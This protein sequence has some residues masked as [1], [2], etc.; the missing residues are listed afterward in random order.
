[1]HLA[2]AAATR[3]AALRKQAKPS[4]AVKPPKPRPAWPAGHTVPK[5]PNF[6]TVGK[7]LSELAARRKAQLLADSI[8]QKEELERR[9]QAV[10]QRRKNFAKSRTVPKSPALKGKRKII[11]AEPA[12]KRRFVPNKMPDFGRAP[13]VRATTKSKAH[14][15][16]NREGGSDAARRESYMMKKG[17]DAGRGGRRDSVRMER[18]VSKPFGLQG[19]DR[20]NAVAELRMMQMEREAEEQNRRRTFRPVAMRE[21]ILDGPTFVPRPKATAVTEAR[22]L[23][24]DASERRARTMAFQR[25]QQERMAEMDREEKRK[26]MEKEQKELEKVTRMLKETQFKP[27]NVPKSHYRPDIEPVGGRHATSMSVQR[28]GGSVSGSQEG[29]EGSGAEEGTPESWPVVRR[30]S[31][32]DEVRKSLSP[33]LWSPDVPASG[34]S[35]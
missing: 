29:M 14:A 33:L 3:A 8:R 21:E 11:V 20:H 30:S 24:P 25:R 35:K 27:R 23:L 13:L 17:S 34:D 15:Q 1:M 6:R 19:V 26:Q 9:E 5:S 12:A 7:P 16:V 28:D 32:F 18:T 31:F 22:N 4:A 2:A 10:K